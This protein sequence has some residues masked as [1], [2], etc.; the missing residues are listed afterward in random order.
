MFAPYISIRVSDRRTGED[1]I[2]IP[3]AKVKNEKLSVS[4]KGNAKVSFGFTGLQPQQ[5]LDR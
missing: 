5:P 1:I 2:F 4:A 3:Y